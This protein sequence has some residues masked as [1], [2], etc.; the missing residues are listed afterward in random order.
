MLGQLYSTQSF[1]RFLVSR[2]RLLLVGSLAFLLAL[3]VMAVSAAACGSGGGKEPTTLTTKLSGESKEGTELTVLEG[4]KV[5]DTA[6]LEGKNVSK[7][8]GKVKYDVYSEKE[9]KTLVTAAG[10]GTVEGEKVT[11]SQ[12]KELEGGKT[13]Y[14][15]ATYEGN[16]SNSASASTCGSEILTVKAKTTL[17]TK[18]IGESKEAEELTVLEGAR[19]KDKATLSGTNSSTATGKVL[20]KIYSDKECKALVKEAGE[21]TLESEAKIPASTEEELEAGKAYYW[22]ATYKGD[23]LH[24]ESTSTCGKEILN[25]KAATK[26]ATSLE[27]E[28]HSGETVEAS[29]ELAV[30]DTATLSGTNSSTAGGTVTYKVYTEKECK[31]LEAEAGEVTVASGTVPSSTDETLSAGTYYWQATYSGD[32]LH[33]ESKSSC[34][35]E[36][37][38]VK[39][40]AGLSTTLAGEGQSSTSIE[41]VEGTG[42][43]DDAALSGPD[44]S[45]A[46]GTVTYDVYSEEQC[47]TLIAEAGKVAVTNGSVPASTE[48]KLKAGTYYWQATYSG[49][50]NNAGETTICGG[51]IAVVNVATSLVTT[52]SGGRQE[53]E[54]ISVSEG[55]A[56]TD[57]ATLNGTNA[58]KA[59]G[60]VTYDVY[61]EDEC[62]TLVAEA[63][64]VTVT[65]GAVPSSSE[66]TLSPGSYYW[67]AF[68]SGDSNNHQS[69]SSC[70]E[71]AVVKAAT[72]LATLLSGGGRSHEEISVLEGTAVTDNA[73]LSGENASKAGGTV[74]YDVYSEKEC[75]TLVAE[76]GK[77]T[78]S[79]GSVVASS[80]EKLKAG[81][82]YWQGTYSGDTNNLGSSSTCGKEILT[83]NKTLLAT[84]L[85]GEGQSGEEIHVVNGAVHDTAT[86]SGESASI[87]TG[88]VKYDVYS[89]KEC[90]T[91]V[92]E[93]GEVTVSSGLVPESR[94]ETLSPGTYYWQATY[95]GDSHNEGSTTPCDAEIAVVGPTPPQVERVEFTNDM[96]VIIDHRGNEP[97]E[98]AEAIEEF[99]GQ[100]NVQWEYSPTHNELVKSW[101]VAYVKRN[102]A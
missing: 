6:K 11:A 54:T 81:T 72:T 71:V 102:D 97:E 56:I 83:V 12:E 32:A 69:T 77:V 18:L 48:E 27:G 46:G 22:Q 76:A 7:A 61:S 96:A 88:K 52:L 30:T 49:D 79:S 70:K 16:E 68:Y 67:Q 37:D 44:A 34:G 57:K 55:T 64:R 29:E 94:E 43:T 8:T 98:K 62:K 31:T 53:G 25:V 17:A 15:Q 63:G 99:A 89:E 59:G 65:D 74:T 58:S 82:Y 3:A 1:A 5:K 39:A 28:G 38:T 78:V 101:P 20:Y 66:E 45:K 24:Q 33:Q 10:E 21:V 50:A 60:T 93:A 80:E 84:S 14:W 86:L 23:T 42:I 13:Y 90:K 2:M 40:A 41:V 9:C 92:A 26:L 85:A 36:I 4:A 73:T 87:A 100:D 51:E 75:K 19:V 95:S 35:K 47:K 91:L